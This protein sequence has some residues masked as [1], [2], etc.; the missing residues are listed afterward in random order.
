MLCQSLQYSK[1]TQ[2]YTNILFLTIIFRYDLSQEIG[3][4]TLCYTVAPCCFNYLFSE[5]GLI[6]GIMQIKMVVLPEML[7]LLSSS[8]F[9]FN[10][11][12]MNLMSSKGYLNRQLL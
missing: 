2:L 9:I 5:A 8:F 4:K 6:Q 10:L 12:H 1:V 11:M 3:Y 7:L